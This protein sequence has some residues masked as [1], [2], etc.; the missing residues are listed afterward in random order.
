MNEVKTKFGLTGIY[1]NI[2]AVT[3]KIYQSAISFFLTRLFFGV[4]ALHSPTIYS[5]NG[6]SKYDHSIGLVYIRLI[7]Q[8]FKEE[9]AFGRGYFELV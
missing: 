9:G 8:I 4:T 2:C 6:K 7:N 5:L 3:P 1:M